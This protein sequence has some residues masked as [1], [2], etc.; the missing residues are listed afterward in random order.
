MRLNE[1]IL[2]KIWQIFHETYCIFRNSGYINSDKECNPNRKG[3]T[4]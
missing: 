3:E 1:S 4:L 2:C